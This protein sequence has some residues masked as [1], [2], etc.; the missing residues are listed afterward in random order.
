MR[1]PA[2]AETTTPASDK[3]S[4]AAL[5]Y[6]AARAAAIEQFRRYGRI[7][8]LW[9][10]LTAATDALLAAHAAPNVSVIAVGGYGR[11]EL[12]PYSD[13]DILLLVPAQASRESSDRVIAMLQHLWDQQ[14]PISHAVRSLEE[15]LASAQADHS[16]AA[17]LMD[18]RLVH[19]DR[20]AYLALKKQL[21]QNVYG[22]DKRGFVVDKLADRDR[23]HLKW[24]DSRFMLEPNVKEGKGGL[25]DLHTL[26]WLARY[27]YGHARAS[28][29]VR[30]DL[31]TQ[32]EWLHYREA[33]LFFSTVRAHMHLLRG[34]ADE[35]LTFDLQTAI[36]SQLKFR[37]RTAQEKAGRL[38][39]RYFQF[40]RQV[41][42]LTRI[43]CAILEEE[44]HRTLVASFVAENVG[45]ALP[46]GFVVESGRI[47]FA[48]E[49]TLLDAPVDSVRIF[50]LAQT[51]AIDIHPR[52]YLAIAR[53]LPRLLH[54]LAFEGEANQWLLNILLGRAPDAAL[55]RMNECGL[56]AALLP[57]FG[58]VVG[59]M[60]YDGYHTYTV[61]EHTLVAI[62]NLAMIEAGAWAQEN[63]L[64]HAVAHE[65]NDRAALFLAMLGH[66]LAKGTGGA[67][68]EKGEAIIMKIAARLG[69]GVASAELAGWLVAHHL[70]F[71][72]TAF[73]RDL[74]DPKTIVDFVAQVQSPERLRLLLLITVADIRAVGPSIWNGWKGSLIRD[75]Y[76]RAMAYMGVG[77]AHSD[78]FD[79]AQQWAQ[80]ADP[81]LHA[82]AQQFYAQRLPP[83]WSQ[84]SHDEQR[85]CLQAYGQWRSAPDEVALVITHDRFRAVSELV[86]CAQQ[87]AGLFRVLAGVMALSG[88]SIVG[89]RIFVRAEGAVIADL[90]VQDVHGN[91][92][93]DEGKRLVALPR[94]IRQGLQGT[95]D[96]AAELPQRSRLT[97]G[98]GV[99]VEPSVFIDNQVSAEASV[100]E[101]NAQ[102]R[103]GLLY[104]ILG[105]M[106][107]CQLQVMS[108]HIATYGARA[109]D[110]FYVK[111]AYGFKLVHPAKIAAVQKAL[112]E[113]IG[114]AGS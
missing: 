75:L 103:L 79:D 105:A 110:V 24:G 22:S 98:R 34:R 21:K 46:A 15:T 82:A 38:M 96:I 84:R 81:M 7:Q 16:I 54:T 56:L 93:A 36:A 32:A 14:I 11:R 109:V 5:Q 45:Q 113:A 95:L 100:I 52:A 41:G 17:A 47:N 97:S 66:D 35:R 65:I 102:D 108:A 92:F 43:F 28:E 39:L 89:A 99:R 42:T 88:A 19:G 53:A 67:H 101:I 72:D 13:V 3:A 55:R 25:R 29:L 48:P 59:M 90:A 63:P 6:Q 40:A 104:Q 12:F 62:G 85:T 9:R 76:R 58:R 57:E 107:D 86:V 87:Q 10:A 1:H 114:G 111:D 8:S 30:D 51:H 64:A 18:A 106:Q 78:G 91:S 70:V 77:V 37:G 27:C 69:V 68:A 83:G 20:K 94:L 73:R 49:S 31:L 4:H 60:Q 112:V 23:R 71:S 44:N 74:D 33:Y 2:T 80:D 61:D 26:T 50:A